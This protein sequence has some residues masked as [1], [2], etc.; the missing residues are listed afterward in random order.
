[1]RIMG[2][3]F[4]PQRFC[5]KCGKWFLSCKCHLKKKEETKN[6]HRVGPGEVPPKKGGI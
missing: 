4:G 3:N 5:G 1:M 2:G 6:E